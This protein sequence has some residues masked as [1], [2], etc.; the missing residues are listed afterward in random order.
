MIRCA[1]CE[2]FIQLD[3]KVINEGYVWCVE[4]AKYYCEDEDC[5]I[6]QGIS[7]KTLIRTSV[8]QVPQ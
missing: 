1:C 4:D 3:D 7:G 2:C 6:N 5:V 8:S